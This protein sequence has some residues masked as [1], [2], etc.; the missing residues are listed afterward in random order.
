MSIS[1]PD[2]TVGYLPQEISRIDGETVGDFLARRTGVG[3]AERVMD[4]PR[5]PSAPVNPAPTT[6][7]GG[8]G[9]L[10]RAWAA[11]I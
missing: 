5:P 2:A 9:T 7:R 8:P 4:D 1:P 10:A 3:D 11:P 6:V